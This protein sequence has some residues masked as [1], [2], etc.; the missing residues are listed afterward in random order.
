MCGCHYHQNDKIQPKRWSFWL[1]I[2]IILLWTA[3]DEHSGEIQHGYVM[4]L[5]FSH[6]TNS[7][8]EIQRRSEAV[9]RSDTWGAVF[10]LEAVVVVESKPSWHRHQCVP[11]IPPPH[12]QPALCPSV[13]LPSAQLASLCW[14]EQAVPA[15]G[16]FNTGAALPRPSGRHGR[17]RNVRGHRSELS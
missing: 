8:D 2:A 15:G 14:S 11:S 12:L 9:R 13:T 3:L 5:C 6:T 4:E 17:W 10:N 16:R 7:F 1:L